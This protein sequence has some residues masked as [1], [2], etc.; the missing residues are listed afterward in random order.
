ML[1]SPTN[2]SSE[3]VSPPPQCPA[4]AGHGKGELVNLFSPRAVADPM[5]TYERLRAEYGPVAPVLVA[6]DLP[7][8]LVLGYREN[9]EV[10][11]TSTRFTRDSRAWNLFKE[12]KVPADSPLL[13]MTEWKPVIRFAEGDEHRRVRSAF[14]DSLARF[15]RRGI[16]R[17]VTRFANDLI[18][19]FCRD[20]KADLVT[21]FSQRL[22]MCVL[23]RLLGLPEEIGP[24]INRA[25]QDTTD[26]ARAAAASNEYLV[27][28]FREAVVRKRA[29]PGNDLASWLIGHPAGLSDLE[30]VQ[31]LRVTVIISNET[32]VSLL[33][34]TLRTV[35][36]DSRFRASLAGGHL[37]LADAVEQ[38]LWDEPPFRT[39][40]GR[41]AIADT[42]V[43][44][45]KIRAGDLMLMG[46]A[47]GNLDPVI[48]PD[49]AAPLF[50]NR[51]HLAFGGGAHECPGQDVSRAIADTGIDT[52]LARL[53]DLSLAV[54]EDQLQWNQA[55]VTR[56]LATLPVTFTPRHTSAEEG[57]A[58][59]ARPPQPGPVVTAAEAGM[60]VAP[61]SAGAGTAPAAS[62]SAAT[63]WASL[64]R[65]LRQLFK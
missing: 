54:S 14:N 12:G 5:G 8:W 29:N 1:S 56:H 4:H 19:E 35:L 21:Q 60:R 3:T 40:V 65:R 32:T 41:W 11:R 18:D 46:L 10:A 15:N 13:P 53:P 16:R 44:G 50:G 27:N 22:P 57:P 47:A 17:H 7:A 33:S 20:G 45:Q 28:A 51:S 24:V 38:T 9:L 6:D 42:E 34:S 39:L 61:C 2:P 37:T 55:W 36:T 43:G 30:V 58:A 26:G 48:R 63:F 25:T 64:G 31:N 49:P 62:T 59:R 52:L 23:T